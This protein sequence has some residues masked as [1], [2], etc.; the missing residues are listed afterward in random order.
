MSEFESNI[1][2]LINVFL[3]LHVHHTEGKKI[4]LDATFFQ[5]M[6]L[7]SLAIAA[8]FNINKELNKTI[9]KILDELPEDMD[10]LKTELK[11]HVNE[12]LVPISNKLK[13]GEK[14]DEYIN[15][16]AKEREGKAKE[17]YG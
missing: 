1:N 5:D 17:L 7:V 16:L 9:E 14:L 15:K 2:A 3:D 10:K 11:N 12:Y 6:T 4:F 13:E 8:N